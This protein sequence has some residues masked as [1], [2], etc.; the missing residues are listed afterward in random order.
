[1]RNKKYFSYFSTKTYVV[2]TQKT[3]SH[4]DGSFEHKKHMLEQMDKNI[5]THLRYKKCLSNPV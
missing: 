2:G 5:L 1:M 3:P 4:W